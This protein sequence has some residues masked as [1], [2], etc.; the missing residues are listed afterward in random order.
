MKYRVVHL[1]VNMGY[2]Y[3][4]L[5]IHKYFHHRFLIGVGFDDWKFCVQNSICF[6]ILDSR[7]YNQ[8]GYGEFGFQVAISKKPERIIITAPG[9]FYFRGKLK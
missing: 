3:Q 5:I 2:H 6:V 8:E 1:L 7:N 9:S 4:W